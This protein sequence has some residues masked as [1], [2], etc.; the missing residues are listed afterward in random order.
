MNML[1]ID[2]TNEQL[3]LALT[4]QDTLVA[5]LMTN[6]K[7][8]HSTRLMPAIVDLMK[9]AEL[10][11]EQLDKIV[12]AQGP[13]SYTGVR[14]GVTTAKTLAWALEIPI[15][16]VSSLQALALNGSLFTGYVWPFFDA[17]RQAIFTAMY[18]FEAGILQEVVPEQHV[19]I[20]AWLEKIQDFKDS[21]LCL[22]PQIHLFREE[23]QAYLGERA[24]MPI[25]ESHI[26]RPGNLIELGRL[27]QSEPVHTIKPNYL[28][29]T[30]AEANWMKQQEK[31]D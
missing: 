10:E 9:T 24:M 6:M 12:V 5:E 25:L 27:K 16:P 11:P 4:K 23:I 8:D 18:R 7:K 31:E 3:G 20:N 30:E 15:H 26:T 14:I 28:R 13:G 2:T 21:I 1:A 19:E 22:S 17:R 29:I